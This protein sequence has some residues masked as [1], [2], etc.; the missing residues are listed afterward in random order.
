[1]GQRGCGHGG[2]AKGAGYTA[3]DAGYADTHTALDEGGAASW[4]AGV[5][6]A[7]MLVASTEADSFESGNSLHATSV[8]DALN[9]ARA[10]I[11]GG[12]ALDTRPFGASHCAPRVV[13]LSRVLFL[14]AVGWS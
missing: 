9:E 12:I 4:S 3:T 11:A 13:R 8:S 14:L 2:F 10:H 7:P 5:G 1:M 6:A